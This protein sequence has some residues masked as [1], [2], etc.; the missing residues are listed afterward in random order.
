MIEPKAD[1][2]M[3]VVF[4]IEKSFNNRNNCWLFFKKYYFSDNHWVI[5]KQ[6][7]KKEKEEKKEKI[8][9]NKLKGYEI[10]KFY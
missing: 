2:E 10:I 1:N 8:T 9:F 3:Y 6:E 7:K 5:E 4:K